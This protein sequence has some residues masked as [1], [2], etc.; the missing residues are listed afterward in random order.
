RN[1]PETP[2]NILNR[3]CPVSVLKARWWCQ[4]LDKRDKTGI[5]NATGESIAELKTSGSL[6]D[7]IYRENPFLFS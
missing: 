7:L 3:I 1:T 5:L 2:S 4:A 6:L